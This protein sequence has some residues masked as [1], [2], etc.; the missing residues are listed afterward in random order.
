MRLDRRFLGRAKNLVEG[1]LRASI[2]PGRL[3]DRGSELLIGDGIAHER[4]EIGVEMALG[5]ILNLF[6]KRI[7][8]GVFLCRRPVDAEARALGEYGMHPLR[9]ANSTA[10][11]ISG[12]FAKMTAPFL[13]VSLGA[14][15][16][17]SCPA[18]G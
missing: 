16:V 11:R 3:D 9:K 17:R 18:Q 7:K 6:G 8:I 5:R 14:V 2:K 1:A 12:A 13:M 10:V 4:F 15:W